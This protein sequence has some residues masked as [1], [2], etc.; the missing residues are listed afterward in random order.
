MASG[1]DISFDVDV[2]GLR[3]LVK[4]FPQVAVEETDQVMKI[5][6]ARLEKDVVEGAPVGVGGGGGLRGSITGKVAQYGRRV[7]GTVGTALAYGEVVEMGRKPGSFPPV[8]PIELWARRKLKVTKEDS[9]SVAYAIA[10]KIYRKGFK[11]AHMFGGAWKANES[12]IHSQLNTIPGRIA[13]RA[14]HGTR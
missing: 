6:I 9:R 13:R 1:L 3:R 5:I 2:E 7:V 8:A 4:K 10:M 12:W 14:Q 11:G